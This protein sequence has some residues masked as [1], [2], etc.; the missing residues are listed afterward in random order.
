MKRQI[1]IEFYEG[2]LARKKSIVECKYRTIGSFNLE[3]T[4]A[5]VL[6]AKN[7][8]NASEAYLMTNIGIPEKEII[9][10]EIGIRVYDRRILLALDEMRGNYSND[11]LEKRIIKYSNA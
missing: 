3:E 4:L 5:Q 2:F 6:S 10:K 7:L 8:T 1:D 9:Q 11:S